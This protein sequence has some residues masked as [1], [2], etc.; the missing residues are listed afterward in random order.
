MPV[1]YHTRLGHSAPGLEGNFIFLPGA[2]FRLDPSVSL[3]KG[4]ISFI[5]F[6]KDTAGTVLYHTPPERESFDSKKACMII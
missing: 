6:I 2:K 4:S 3:V 5:F 1:Q